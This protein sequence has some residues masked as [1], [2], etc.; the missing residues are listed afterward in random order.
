MTIARAGTLPL[1]PGSADYFCGAVCLEEIAASNSGPAV[2]VVR[3]SFAP[4]ARTAWHTHP[5]GQALYI[6]SGTGLVQ[7]EG[8]AVQEV[9]PGDSVWFAPGERHWH[10]AAPDGLMVHLAVQLADAQ[11]STT[12]WAEHVSDAEYANR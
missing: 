6:L 2:R 1:K 5:C 8:E 9:F 7:R 4:A 3:V 10:G 12:V 11:G